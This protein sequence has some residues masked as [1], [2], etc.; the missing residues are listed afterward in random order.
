MYFDI[1]INLYV[2]ELVT[3]HVLLS[4]LKLEIIVLSLSLSSINNIFTFIQFWIYVA[5]HLFLHSLRSVRMYLRL[6][7][8]WTRQSSHWINLSFEFVSI[9]SMSSM[10]PKLISDRDGFSSDLVRFSRDQR[11]ITLGIRGGINI[12]KTKDSGFSGKIWRRPQPA[13]KLTRRAAW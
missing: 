2:K 5:F 4:L 3:S 12:M 13:R 8:G 7:R 1:Y 9:P 10:C 6:Y 11:S